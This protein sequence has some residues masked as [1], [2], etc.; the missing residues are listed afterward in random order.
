VKKMD[1]E[2]KGEGEVGETKE[3]GEALSGLGFDTGK[4]ISTVFNQRGV[5]FV[6]LPAGQKKPPDRNEWQK[7]ENQY[8]FQEIDG[9]RGARNIGLVASFGYIILDVDDPSALNGLELPKSTKWETR[10]NAERYAMWFKCED[11]RSALSKRKG[12]ADKGK[13]ELFD[14]HQLVEVED[15]KGKKTLQYAPIGEIKLSRTYEVIPPSW[16]R[17]EE[18]GNRVEYRFLD[19]GEIAPRTI[20]LEW[21]I[22]SLDKLG[23]VFRPNQLKKLKK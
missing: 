10:T 11:S 17:L 6:L 14:S 16:K 2:K 1:I 20:S 5:G 22:S 18:N 8:S 7:K 23:I 19:G 9:Y 12:H 3:G 13:L 4:E 15:K 21:L